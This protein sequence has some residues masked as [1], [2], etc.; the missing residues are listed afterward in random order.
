VVEDP[1][2]TG[3]VA[4]NL[5]I[6]LVGYAREERALQG[7]PS[8]DVLLRGV[9]RQHRSIERD[10][11]AEGFGDGVEQ[12]FP[13]QVRNER[14]V[15]LQQQAILQ[16]RLLKASDGPLE[17]LPGVSRHSSCFEQDIAIRI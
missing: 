4:G 17:V 15:D 14:V 1:A 7:E 8:E 2:R 11:L 5:G 13:S 16:Q 12:R 10:D 6:D 9:D 3:I